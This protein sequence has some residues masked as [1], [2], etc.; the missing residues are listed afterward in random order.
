M[1]ILQILIA[2]GALLTHQTTPQAQA[3]L[4]SGFT[5]QGQLQQGGAPVNGSVHLRFTLW[6]AAGSGQPPLGG[7]QLGASQ[8]LTDV[9]VQDGVFTVTL[10]AGGE[11]GSTVFDGNGRWLQIE[12][13][14]DAGCSSL[15]ILSPRQP[16]TGTPYSLRTLSAPWSG[17]TEVPPGFADGVDNVGDP[18]WSL[19]GDDLY[20]AVGSVGIGTGSPTSRLEILGQNG[21]AITGFQPFLTLR[22]TNSSS[23]RGVIQSADGHIVFYPDSSLGSFP[24]QVIYTDTGA[25]GIGAPDPPENVRLE[26]V[27]N[28][29]VESAISGISAIN[30]VGVRGEGF[31]GE[32]VVGFSQNTCGVR[33]AGPTGVEGVAFSA[34]DIGISG[35][36]VVNALAG[37]FTG[38]VE[39]NGTLI[40]MNE[41][42]RIDHPL[43]PSQKYLQHASV[44]S[45]EMKNVY[46]GSVTTNEGGRATVQ[47]PDY[48]E[49]LN[50]DFQ[51]QLT[52]IGQFAQ[53]IVSRE[54]ENNSFEIQTDQPHVKVSWQVTG[55]RNDAWAQKHPIE[56]EKKKSEED[57]GRYLTPELFGQPKEDG[58]NYRPEM[59][60]ENIADSRV[61]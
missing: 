12:V 25:V 47:L 9:P 8:L 60:E 7:N 57:R 11:F 14:A 24:A 38:N 20:R 13:C 10:N 23:K 4:G 17:L 39:V 28:R 45:P 2:A 42:S 35:F 34:G 1:R 46:D 16:I 19:S 15:S 41:A 5:Y 54:I 37:K 36:A 55:I 31:N 6:D 53:A 49:A 30:G 18:S 33:G 48:F 56:V 3:P 50:R 52:V 58:I 21:L 61:E 59:D 27:A 26:V 32:G 40:K 29:I 51:Y 22:D 43:D 44:E